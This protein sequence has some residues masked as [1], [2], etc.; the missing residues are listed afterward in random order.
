MSILP[1]PSPPE[2]KKRMF[3]KA[4][5]NLVIDFSSEIKRMLMKPKRI[6]LDKHSINEP[7]IECNNEYPLLYFVEALN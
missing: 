5:M 3:S 7:Y 2:G 1:H 6:N 4:L